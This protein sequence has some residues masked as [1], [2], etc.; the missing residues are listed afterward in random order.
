MWTKLQRSTQ[1]HAKKCNGHVKSCVREQ[2]FNFWLSKAKTLEIPKKSPK[3]PFEHNRNNLLFWKKNRRGRISIQKL[4]SSRQPTLDTCALCNSLCGSK[5]HC[6][7]IWM[8]KNQISF[9]YFCEVWET[10]EGKSE[11]AKNSP[12]KQRW[13]PPPLSEPHFTHTHTHTE[14]KRVCSNLKKYINHKETWITINA[15]VCLELHNAE[16]KPKSQS[17]CQLHARLGGGRCWLCNPSQRAKT[18]TQWN[19]N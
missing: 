18:K 2:A 14:Q 13:S 3:R 8:G 11:S 1:L 9:W 16:G 6:T 19:R 17:F 15:V 12:Q 10:K 5:R 7:D 4:I